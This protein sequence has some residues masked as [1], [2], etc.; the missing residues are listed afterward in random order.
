MSCPR[1]DTRQKAVF[2]QAWRAAGGARVRAGATS[3]GVR[4]CGWTQV[5]DAAPAVQPEY[6]PGGQ[7]FVVPFVEAL[8]Q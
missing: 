7:I 8:G 6:V 5:G 2:A 4:G 1:M 3:H